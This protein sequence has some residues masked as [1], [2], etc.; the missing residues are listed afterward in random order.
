MRWKKI[1]K[2]D[3]YTFIF[4]KFDDEVINKKNSSLDQSKSSNFIICSTV[5]TSTEYRYAI[6]EVHENSFDDAS[7]KNI[8][9]KACH[10]VMHVLMAPYA[11]ISWKLLQELPSQERKVYKKWRKSEEEEFTSRLAD[12]I[13]SLK[14]TQRSK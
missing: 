4:T 13:C 8:D 3:D 7:N 6:I 11:N 1:F 14:K 5:D 10:E 9:N 12:I 2:L